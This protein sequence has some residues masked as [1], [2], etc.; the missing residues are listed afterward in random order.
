MIAFLKTAWSYR[1]TEN[2]ERAQQHW[3]QVDLISK[4]FFIVE[5]LNKKNQPERRMLGDALGAIDYS[6]QLKAGTARI[7]VF[8]QSAH[9]DQWVCG[10][11]RRVAGKTMHQVHLIES[12]KFDL[13]QSQG[14]VDDDG[15]I[16]L[17]RQDRAG[18]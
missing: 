3:K 10:V 13:S 17:Y 14:S 12:Y 16:T 5:G 7:T 9:G 2:K 8:D 15:L 11:I 6:R 4:C 1:S 18:Q